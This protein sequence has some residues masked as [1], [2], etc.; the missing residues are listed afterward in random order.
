MALGVVRKTCSVS[1]YSFQHEF[2]HI[3]G[4]NHNTESNGNVTPIEPY[5]FGHWHA[6]VEA[7][8]RTIMSMISSGCKPSCFQVQNY[9]NPLVTT[10]D[11]FVTGSASHN[12]ALVIAE[13]API[14]AQ[15]RPS[16]GRIFADGFN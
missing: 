5:A 7:G 11:G 16:L 10:D 6:D 13:L 9:S 14:T 8:Y 3:L 1:A 12:N 15:Y 4:A 2:G